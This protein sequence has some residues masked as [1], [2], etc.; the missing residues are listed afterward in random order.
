MNG[1]HCW[2]TLLS[3]LLRMLL[4]DLLNWSHESLESRRIHRQQSNFFGDCID[5]GCS[6]F[7]AKKRQLAEVLTCLVAHGGRF[8]LTL[9]N[10]LGNGLAFVKN[11]EAIT[12]L[13]LL[14]DW[15]S[16]RIGFQLQSVN[17][18]LK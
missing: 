7:T 18:I 16:P 3:I 13:A 10:L 12:N 17:D 4:H 8:S 6:G 9:N 5:T 15:S 11:V 1:S 2:R 14:N